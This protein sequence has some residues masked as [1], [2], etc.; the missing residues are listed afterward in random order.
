[1]GQQQMHD[2]LLTD[3]L[4]FVSILFGYHSVI[5]LLGEDKNACKQHT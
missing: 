2:A 5:D 4:L 1:M 3:L